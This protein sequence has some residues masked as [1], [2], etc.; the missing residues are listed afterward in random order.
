M[1][2]IKALQSSTG[3]L[4]T[5]LYPPHCVICSVSLEAR[6]YLCEACKS[7][8]KRIRPPYCKI[9]SQPFD[10]A[11]ESDFSCANCADR[12]FHFE[13]A[14]TCY[15]SSGVVRDLVHR[16]KYNH[17]Y[18]L[19]HLLSAWLK[20]GLEDPRIGS[21][22]FDLIVPVPLHPSRERKRQFNQAYVLATMLSKQTGAPLSNC[23]KR[24]RKTPTQT[25]FD[26]AER[27]ENLL[28]AFKM[29]KNMDVQGKQLILVDDVF[30]TG[31]TVDECA[32]VLK[33]AGAQSIRV[34]TVARG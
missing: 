20:E 13:S 16:F 18:Y 4:L 6:E 17:E 24:I 23:L 3:A 26:R 11:I 31:S 7:D 5:L 10:G 28:N 2:I 27:M 14:V 25:R 33:N 30:T 32:R 1:G 9:C 8:A 21:K 22:P 29:R 12:R 19:R 15:R 34:I